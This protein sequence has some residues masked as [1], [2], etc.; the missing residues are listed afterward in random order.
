MP[1]SNFLA[2]AYLIASLGMDYKPSE[3][4]TVLLSPLTG[5]L[6]IVAMDELSQIGA[7]GVEPGE[8]TRAEI[9]GFIRA[10]F[11][12]KFW[13]ER[14]AVRSK[15]E[16]FSNFLDK[17]QNLKVDWELSLNLKMGD[18]ITARIATH[19]IYDEEATTDV[20]FRELF[21]LGLSYNF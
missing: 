18:Y 8:R 9:G 4:F 15:L 3:K 7:F 13:E 20:Q 6:T 19:L 10:L 11:Q 21:G 1:I 2:P 14:L 16:L 12:S 5:R 17:P